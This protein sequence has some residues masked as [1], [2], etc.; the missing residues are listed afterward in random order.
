M[1]IAVFYTKV[2]NRLLKPLTA[3]NAL[4]APLPLRQ[5]L[6]VIDTYIDD[7]IEQSRIAS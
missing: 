7:Y 6:H 1:R 5:A 3:A 2:H 4:P